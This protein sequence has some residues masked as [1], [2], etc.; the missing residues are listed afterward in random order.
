L[1]RAQKLQ[2]VRIGIAAVNI[3]FGFASAKN[4]N[5]NF[6]FTNC[7]FPFSILISPPIGKWQMGNGK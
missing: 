4:Y 5:N 7:H 6:P 3:Y 1:H 2:I